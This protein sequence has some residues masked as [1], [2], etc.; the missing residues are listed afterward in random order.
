MYLEAGFDR[1]AVRSMNEASQAWIAESQST[2]SYV[3]LIA[4]RERQP[5]GGIGIMIHAWPPH[6]HHPA[7]ARR[8]YILNL[9]V[10]PAHRG[11][12]VGAAL[13]AEAQHR[14]RAAGVAYAS[15]H[16]T[17]PATP[18]YRRLGWSETGEMAKR[19]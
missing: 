10:E 12:G 4:E 3:G 13:V 17:E 19:L 8:G 1:A 9:F 18:L 16:P 7:D 5:I 6:P 14:L 2:H 11:V 15:L